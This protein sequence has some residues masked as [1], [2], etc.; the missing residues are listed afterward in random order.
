MIDKRLIVFGVV[1]H[2]IIF[3]AAA[4][5]LLYI[6]GYTWLIIPAVL[7]IIVWEVYTYK[8]D[9]NLLKMPSPE[10][11]EGFEGIALTDINKKGKIDIK[12]RI[13]NARSKNFIE[14]GKRV[15]I[16]KK[17]GKTFEVERANQK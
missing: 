6:F 17:D 9:I 3:S 2:T 1:E 13:R 10:K 16:V 4:A 12:G 5:A 11:I 8:R 14:K 7:A 15:R